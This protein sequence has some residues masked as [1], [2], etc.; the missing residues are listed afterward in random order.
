MPITA[1][2]LVCTNVEKDCSPRKLE[3]KSVSGEV[4]DN[5]HGL[6]IGNPTAVSF[7]FRGKGALRVTHRQAV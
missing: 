4:V 7:P 5:L 3:K 6:R 1:A 2:Q